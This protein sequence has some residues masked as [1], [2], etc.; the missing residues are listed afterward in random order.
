VDGDVAAEC[1]GQPDE[2]REFGVAL[3][4][5]EQPQAAPRHVRLRRLDELLLCVAAR[6]LLGRDLRTNGHQ[7]MIE[8]CGAIRVVAEGVR[9]SFVAWR[10]PISCLGHSRQISRSYLNR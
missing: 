4:L 6:P 10:T 8:F 7:R 5:Q 1:G 9:P 3:R 2:R